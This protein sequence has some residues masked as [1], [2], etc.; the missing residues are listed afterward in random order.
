MKSFKE[1]TKDQEFSDDDAMVLAIEQIVL[2]EMA[3][4]SLLTESSLW[5]EKEYTDLYEDVKSEILSRLTNYGLTFQDK[6]KINDV[7]KVLGFKLSKSNGPTLIDLLIKSGKTLLEFFLAA[8]RGD[9]QKVKEMANTKIKA[10]DVVNFILKLDE[11]TLHILSAPLHTIE[12][13]TGWHLSANI[14]KVATATKDVIVKKVKDAFQYIKD[15][16]SPLAPKELA[17][18]KILKAINSIQA[19]A[20]S[21]ILEI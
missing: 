10:E 5:E 8:I 2:Y 6:S 4:S 13:L 9:K 12:A 17:A 1:F 19:Q 18:N 21:K 20:P 16:L 14:K 15:K 7:I 3:T 11:A